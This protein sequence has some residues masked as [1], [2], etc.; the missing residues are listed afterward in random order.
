MLHGCAKLWQGRRVLAVDGVSLRMPHVQ[1]CFDAF[2]KQCDQNKKHYCIAQGSLLF[3]VLNHM[4]LALQVQSYP[5]CERT[6]LLDQLPHTRSGDVLLLD[7]GYPAFWVFQALQ[8]AKLDCVVRIEPRL[9]HQFSAFARSGLDEQI[10]LLEPSAKMI[11]VCRIRN[12]PETPIRM[13]AI[14]LTLPNGSIAILATTLLDVPAADI[15]ALYRLRWRIEEEIK[16]LKCRLEIERFT[17]LTLHAVMQD[18]Y[19]ALL[20]A[21]LDALL[22][23]AAYAQLSGEPRRSMLVPRVRATALLLSFLPRLL[24]QL[25]VPD[26]KAITSTLMSSAQ[27]A[28]PSRSAPRPKTVGRAF[29]RYNAYKSVRP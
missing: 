6:L 16:H 3:D 17:G 21:N 2:G 12:L 14:R 11:K 10:L 24:L 5:N 29:P 8:T 18:L 7:R 23:G 19:A 15:V 4:A 13:R 20:L 28:R 25:I 22:S 27:L 26:W 1:P 9:W